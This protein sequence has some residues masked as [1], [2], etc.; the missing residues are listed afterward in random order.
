MANKVI[1]GDQMT[2]VW[3]VD[4][5]KV[6]HLKPLEI[7]KFACYLSHIFGPK[8]AVKRGNIHDYLGMDLDYS[9]KGQVK[10]S[11]IKYLKKILAAFP[12]DLL[13][14]S[15]TPAARHLFTVH[16]DAKTE[17]LSEEE[18]MSFHH[19]VAQLLFMCSRSR[20]DVQLPVAF[21]TTRVKKPDVHDWGN[22]KRV[23]KYLNGT[24]HMRLT[25]SAE[26]LHCVRWWIDTYHTTPTRTVV[27]T[28]DP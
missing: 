15:N 2:M 18:A 8:L 12:E 26:S 13:S 28:M 25:L 6:S 1:D 11:M 27:D 22:L 23:M 7:M 4:D 14:T 16:D 24:Q 10:V 5:L 20:R 3:H 19:S 9:E 17:M 21:L